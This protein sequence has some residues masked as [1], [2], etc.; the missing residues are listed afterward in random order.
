MATTFTNNWK[1]IIDKL[2]SLFR[3]EFKATMPIVIGSQEQSTN[4][5]FMR[6]TPSSTSLIESHASA[7][8]RE[9]SIGLVYNFKDAN[10]RKT[11]LDHI[12]RMASRVESLVQDNRTM[13]L[14]DSSFAFDCKIQST[15]IEPQAEGG[16]IV[17][18]DY[19]CLHEGNYS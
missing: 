15:D 7:E 5:Q 8:I 17:T 2:V 11:S 4:S 9:F 13:T 18:F 3:A 12:T 19:T 14:T 10:V 16:Y 6:L 1:N